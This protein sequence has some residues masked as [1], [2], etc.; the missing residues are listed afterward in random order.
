[1]CIW[2]HSPCLLKVGSFPPLFKSVWLIMLIDS[3]I[4]CDRESSGEHIN[5]L[6]TIDVVFCMSYELFK[7]GDVAVEVLSLHL[8]S[9]SQGHP[10]LLLLQHVSKLSF[11]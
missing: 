7:L 8:D 1:M 4:E 2:N 11:E 10:S 9:L 6:R 5:G 3:L